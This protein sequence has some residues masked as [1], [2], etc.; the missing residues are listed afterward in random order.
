MLQ[1]YNKW[2]EELL[3]SFCVAF[4]GLRGDDDDRICNQI[5]KRFFDLIDEA[6]AKGYD[7]KRVFQTFFRL[8]TGEPDDGQIFE[9]CYST[10]CDTGRKNPSLFLETFL[11]ELPRMLVKDYKRGAATDWAKDFLKFAITLDE[12]PAAFRAATEEKKTLMRQL[13]ADISPVFV[14]NQT[15]SSGPIVVKNLSLIRNSAAA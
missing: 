4:Y 11:E 6:K 12:F 13:A 8:F 2:K 3:P 1:N 5:L 10:T 15:D 9:S 14:K 7:D